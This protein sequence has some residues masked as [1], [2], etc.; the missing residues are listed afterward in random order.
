MNGDWRLV[1][2]KWRE[3]FEGAE[4][5]FFEVLTVKYIP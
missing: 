3:T 4:V 2:G 1:I 5:Y